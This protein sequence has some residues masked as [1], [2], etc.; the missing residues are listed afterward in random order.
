MKI[1]IVWEHGVSKWSMAPFEGLSKNHDVTVF[2]G[3]KNKFDVSTVVQDKV[4]LTRKDEL[5][6]ALKNPAFAWQHLRTPY[7]RFYFYL[8]A[9]ARHITDDFDVIICHDGSRSLSTLTELKKTKPFKLVVSYAENIPFRSIYDDKTDLIKKRS[10]EYIDL[11][12][13]WCKTIEEAL[14][15]EGVSNKIRTIPMGVSHEIFRPQPKDLDLCKQ[16][17]LDPDKFTFSYIGKLV[18]WKGPQ[19]ILYAANLLRK[20]GINN[21]QIAITGKGAQLDNMKKIIADA[22]LSDCV[23]FTGFLPYEKVGRLHNLSDCLILPSIPIITWQEQFGMVLVE[24]MSCRKPILAANSG[25]IPEVAEGAALLHTP[26][27]WHELARDMET[28]MNDRAL[29][30]KLGDYGYQR[31]ISEYTAEK[32]SRDYENALNELLAN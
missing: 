20:R 9:L 4:F 7:R 29:C 6:S 17:G 10:W 5:L 18:S 1:G 32:T 27:N 8:N 22:G 24:A 26:G 21:F 30:A 13:P 11:L 2:V 23:V 14:G 31:A 3:K 16:Y 28:L 12:T 15:E 19:Y 25:S